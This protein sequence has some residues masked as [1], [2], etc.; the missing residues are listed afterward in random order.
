M[1]NVIIATNQADSKTT[2]IFVVKGENGTTGFSNIT[3]PINAVPFG[4]TPT[5]YIDNIVAQNQGSCQ[6]NSNYYVWYT[7]HFST[8]EIS[9]MFTKSSSIP[10]FP[11][12]VMLSLVIILAVSFTVVFTIRKRNDRK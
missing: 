11:S 5:V 4:T 7:T 6:D 1:S 9:I 10:E 2:I 3:I 12:S 8:H